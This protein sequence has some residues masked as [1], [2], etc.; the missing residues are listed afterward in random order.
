MSRRCVVASGRPGPARIVGT[1]G[2]RWVQSVYRTPTRWRTDEPKCRTY[3][4]SCKV[5]DCCREA[6]CAISSEV[7]PRARGNRA[8]R[9]RRTPGAGR[10]SHD[11]RQRR[12]DAG[13]LVR[14]SSLAGRRRCHRPRRRAIPAALTASVCT[15]RSSGLPSAGRDVRRRGLPG[16]APRS[17]SPLPYGARAEVQDHLGGLASSRPRSGRGGGAAASHRGSRGCGAPPGKPCCFPRGARAVE[18]EVRHC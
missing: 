9:R 13:V 7:L 2:L 8:R 18:H 5:P 1:A 6:P 4:V 14:R 3:R 12:R 17:G 15:S 16:G 10:S 11:C